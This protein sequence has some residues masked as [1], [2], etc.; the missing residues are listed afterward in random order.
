MCPPYHENFCKNNGKSLLN[1][2]IKKISN[3]VRF[4]NIFTYQAK[5]HVLYFRNHLHMLPNF[6]KSQQFHQFFSVL[7]E[8]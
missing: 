8:K 7:P 4:Y 3:L 1:S 5:I 2:M 6:C